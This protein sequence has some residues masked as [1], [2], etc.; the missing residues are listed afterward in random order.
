MSD[1]IQIAD[2]DPQWPELFAREAANIRRALG[3]G[4][5][6]IEH[7]GSTSVPGLAAKPIVDVLLVVADSADEAAYVPAL[8]AA[9]YTL[10]IREPEWY[11]HRMLK[12]SAEGRTVHLH[13]FS[14]SCVE[15]S[16]MLRFR[17]WLRT[18][19]AD[20]SLYERTKRELAR[21]EWKYMQNYADAKTR[22]V[23]EIMVRAN[24]SG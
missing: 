19:D 6:Q 15:I 3:S 16:R 4:A 23:D 8:D 9:G 21:Q 10:R 17:D 1:P 11:Q 7:V 5:L 22:V 12:G 14:V 2:Y 20:R 13:V 18:S 24:Q